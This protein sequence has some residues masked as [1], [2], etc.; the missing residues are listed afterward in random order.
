MWFDGPR[1]FLAI[2]WHLMWFSEPKNLMWFD[3]P[4]SNFSPLKTSCGIMDPLGP[5]YHM[6]LLWFSG[7][8]KV[9]YFTSDTRSIKTHQ[10]FGTIKPHEILNGENPSEFRSTKSNLSQMGP[11]NHIRFSKRQIK[12]G[13]IKPHER[14]IHWFNGPTFFDTHVE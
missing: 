5:L 4:I 14:K 11:S 10:V 9:H 13:S 6:R 8:Y 12:N 2:F 3:G 7:K 1:S